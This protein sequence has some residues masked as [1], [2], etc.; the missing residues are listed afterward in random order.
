MA[1]ARKGIFAR[2]RAGACVA[3]A[4]AA[5]SVA[6]ALA[7][8]LPQPSPSPAPGPCEQANAIG[9]IV[10]RPGLG[11]PT[12]NDG[13]ACVVPR[14]EG[15]LELGYRTQTTHGSDGT[16]ALAVFPLAL[17]RAGFSTRMEALLQPPAQSIRSGDTLGGVF[18]P[19]VGSQDIGFG[20]KRMLDDRAGFQDA[21]GIFVSVPSGAPQGPNGFSA[22][23]PT[24]TL[25]YTA[26]FPLS[27]TLGVS[28]TQ[29]LIDNA[30]PLEA[31]G[32]SHFFS[33]QPS[34]TIS[35]GFATNTSLL[36]SDQ[37]TSPLGPGG[38]TGNRG[39]V[40][41]QWVA[42]PRLVF[43]VEYELNA[44]PGAPAGSQ[45]AFGGGVAVLF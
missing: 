7:Q 39:L 13:S 31:G 25:G 15:M 9:A 5:S 33:Y 21:L 44:L 2:G 22:G 11:R 30:A 41:L 40:G 24:Y 32:A 6:P 17:L 28:I 18:V 36:V 12:A 8:T 23:A 35:Y 42:S 27:P 4:L 29:N 1:R 10:D 16:S 34:L 38:G 45:H 37:I 43:D 26:A 3:F 20:L 14:G 19:A